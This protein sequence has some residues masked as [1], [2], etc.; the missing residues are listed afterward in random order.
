MR[1]PAG[2]AHRQ[3]DAIPHVGGG[4]AV[5]GI[6]NDP[7]VAPVVGGDEWMRVRV[8][9]KVHAPGERARRQR[10]VFRIGRRARVSDD[11]APAVQRAGRRLLIVPIGG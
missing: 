3:V 7:L 9:M 1:E 11:R 10:A 6:V 2:I 5:V 4:L 8:V